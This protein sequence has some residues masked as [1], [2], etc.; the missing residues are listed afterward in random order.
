MNDQNHPAPRERVEKTSGAGSSARPRSRLK[1]W[2]ARLLLLGVTCVLGLLA[3]EWGVRK[4]LPFFDPRN[5]IIRQRNAE[6]LKL[7]VPSKTVRLG[8]PK[9]EFLVSITYNR[10]AF[11]DPKDFTQAG[12]ND[13]FVVG[14]SQTFG[15]GVE[16][17][18]RFSA[19]LEQTTG[20]PA[21]NIAI[22]GNDFFGYERLLQFVQ[23]HGAPVRNVILGVCM[24][25]DLLDYS[26]MDKTLRVTEPQ[27][28]FSSL[29]KRLLFWAKE[30]SALAV[31]ASYTLKH[32]AVTRSL[33]ERL[34]LARSTEEMTQTNTYDP[35]ALAAS[36]DVL[37]D[38]SRRYNLVVLIIPNRALWYGSNIAVEQ[39]VH[40]EFVRSLRDAG[41]NVVDLRP[42]FEAAGDPLHFY[43]KHDAHLNRAG[44]AAAAAA[45]AQ[46]LAAS[47]RWKF[48]REQSQ[49]H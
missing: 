33:M 46:R 47:E 38:F 44:H 35:K 12:T 17:T 27:P 36:R 21:F 40:D 43:F 28:S 18:N 8:T 19:V 37:V 1:E 49:V 24:E 22:P 5:Q 3:L 2:A 25:N 39:E 20:V 4:F 16:E 10:W 41:L 45:L 30:H 32:W 29:R 34:G 23:R 48:L 11:W 7:G 14:D 26:K 15:W 31:C 6:G 42:G 9:G 13:I